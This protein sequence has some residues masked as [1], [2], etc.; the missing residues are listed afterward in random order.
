MAKENQTAHSAEQNEV[1]NESVAQIITQSRESISHA[2]ALADLQVDLLNFD[3]QTATPDKIEALFT[4]HADSP[5]AQRLKDRALLTLEIRNRFSNDQ[6]LDRFFNIKTLG[7][8]RIQPTPVSFSV[9]FFNPIDWA[10]VC[11]KGKNSFYGISKFLFPKGFSAVKGWEE[12]E[13]EKE[14][15]TNVEYHRGYGITGLRRIK[16]HELR[17]SMNREVSVRRRIP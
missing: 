11:M 14:Y 8:V 12:I 15:D 10:K 3:M 4:H 9:D 17:H 6:L 7:P 13:D 16:Q 1:N 5:T 2:M